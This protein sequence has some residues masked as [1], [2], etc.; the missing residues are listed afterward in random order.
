[1]AF[2]WELFGCN[3][4]CAHLGFAICEQ[5]SC[6]LFSLHEKQLLNKII[7]QVSKE[8]N[9]IADACDALSTQMI[10][11]RQNAFMKKETKRDIAL[12]I[13]ILAYIEDHIVHK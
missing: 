10:M 4:L 6:K 5:V 11:I 12:L 8:V 1:M 9:H 13:H 2:L 7:Q 3:S